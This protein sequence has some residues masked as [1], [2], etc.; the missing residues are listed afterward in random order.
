MN[1]IYFNFYVLKMQFVSMMAHVYHTLWALTI[2]VKKIGDFKDK[3][4]NLDNHNNHIIK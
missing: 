2:N 3:H 1:E 4:K